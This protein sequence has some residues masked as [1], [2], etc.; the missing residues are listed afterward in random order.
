MDESVE[1]INTDNHVDEVN[2][3]S[4]LNIEEVPSP[5]ID[6]PN[7]ECPWIIGQLAWARVGN[8]PFWPCMVTIDPESRIYYKMRGKFFKS[9]YISFIKIISVFKKLSPKFDCILSF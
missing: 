8:F 4:M 3:S 7:T 6:S 9:M 2:N 1:E 5:N